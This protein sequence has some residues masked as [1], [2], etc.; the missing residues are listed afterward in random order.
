MGEFSKEIMFVIRKKDMVFL[1]G[2]M[3]ESM[4]DNGQWI[5][6]ME[7]ESI[8]RPMEHLRLDIGF[9]EYANIGMLMN[10]K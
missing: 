1:N 8:F 9:M 7:R 4:K 5:S 3:E 6:N 2:V 10:K